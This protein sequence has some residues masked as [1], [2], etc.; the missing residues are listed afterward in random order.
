MYIRYVLV[1]LVVG[2]WALPSPPT[3]D[4]PDD[5]RMGGDAPTVFNPDGTRAPSSHQKIETT[6]GSPG[7]SKKSIGNAIKWKGPAEKYFHESTFNG[8]YDGRFADRTLPAESRNEHLRALVRTYLATMHALG[9]ETW[10][11]HGSLLGWWWNRRIMPWDSDIDVQVSERALAF[12]AAHHNMS[13]HAFQDVSWL[14]GV[15]MGGQGVSMEKNNHDEDVDAIVG[16]RKYLLEINPNW[17]NASYADKYNV[18]DGRWIDMKTGLYIDIT[19]VRWNQSSPVPGTLYCKDRHHY[20]SRQIF[21]LRTSEFEGVPAKIPYA[22]QE[23]LAEEYG[24]K[25]LVQTV[26]RKEGHVFD[27]EK[28]EWVAMTRPGQYGEGHYKK[29]EKA[30]KKAAGTK[31][32]SP[33]SNARDEGKEVRLKPKDGRGGQYLMG[34]AESVMTVVWRLFVGV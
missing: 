3:V 4:R 8:H 30:K 7:G 16:K 34:N 15:D 32:Q 21:P 27:K 1:A 9:A 17:K 2:A 23:L 18:I 19:S 11:M 14:G 26:Y 13:V 31:N 6:P 10:I 24:T 22:Y 25:S 29:T 12:L 28:M 20:L 33:N 5:K